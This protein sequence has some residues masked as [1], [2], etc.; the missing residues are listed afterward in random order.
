MSH[1]V[2][3]SIKIKPNGEIFCIG[4]DN[5]VFPRYNK[6]CKFN[7]GLRELFDD[8]IGGNIQPIES[9]NNYKWNYVLSVSKG[10]TT[11]ERFNNFLNALNVKDNKKYILTSGGINFVK[12]R[13]GTYHT[14][15]Q[16]TDAS[17]FNFFKANMLVKRFKTY[18]FEMEVI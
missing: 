11:E 1:F 18:N 12:Q 15:E 14:T 4:D 2:A 6:E 13:G 8:L 3:K 7:G 10:E 16:K 17:V 5:N 9:A